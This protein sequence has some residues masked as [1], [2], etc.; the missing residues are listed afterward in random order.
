MSSETTIASSTAADPT[1]VLSDLELLH[2]FIGRNLEAGHR[3]QPV[4]ECLSEFHRYLESVNRLR[5]EIR[6][7]LERSLR[8][9]SAE[10]LDVEDIIRRG[11][12]RL[13]ERGIE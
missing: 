1:R 13:A 7:G 11:R 10:E 2:R 8:G 3:E 9:E 5:D 4:D 6:P 12:E